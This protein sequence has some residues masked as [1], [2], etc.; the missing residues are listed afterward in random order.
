MLAGGIEEKYPTKQLDPHLSFPW[1]DVHHWAR[2]TEYSHLLSMVPEGCADDRKGGRQRE[3]WVISFSEPNPVFAAP[4]LSHLCSR[5]CHIHS[6]TLQSPTPR[7]SA[8]THPAKLR[9]AAESTQDLVVL[10]PLADDTTAG[11]PEDAVPYVSL[12]YCTEVYS[13]ISF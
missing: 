13:Y 8:W 11:L 12:L 9:A 7:H 4:D 3:L 10:L 2:Q 5:C 1:G 6:P